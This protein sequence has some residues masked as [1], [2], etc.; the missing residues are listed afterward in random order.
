MRSLLRILSLRYWRRCPARLLLVLLSIA[1]GV[2]AWA[3][4][5]ALNSHLNHSSRVSA[6]PLASCA[7]FLLSN[8]D[9]GVPRALVE[10]LGRIA[11]IHAVRPLIIQRVLLPDLNHQTALLLGAD[12]PEKSSEVVDWDISIRAASSKTYLCALLGGQ[13][14]AL[15]GRELDRL[16]PPDAPSCKVLVGGRTTAVVRTGTIEQARGP[17]AVLAGNVLLMPCAEA[18]T[19]LGRPEL[20]SRIDLRLETGADREAVRQQIEAVVVGAAR[21]SSPEASAQQ[22]EGM[23]APLTLGLAFCGLGALLVGLFLIYNTLAVSVADRRREIA[24]LRALGAT[25]GQVFRLFLGEALCLGIVGTLLGLPLGIGLAKLSLGTMQ[26]VLSEVLLPLSGTAFQTTAG[27]W[28]ES[29]LAGLGTTLLATLVP[30]WHATRAGPIQVLRR[31]PAWPCNMLRWCR[32]GGIPVLTMASVGCV[33]CKNVLPL[34]V[35]T[36]GGLLLIIGV[37]LLAIPSV[38]TGAARLIQGLAR[39]FPS[40]G[41]RIAMDNVVS[42]PGRTGLVVAALAASVALLLMT[43]GLIRSNEAA[44]RSWV[45]ETIGGDLF[46][47]AGGPLSASGQ[48]LPMDETTVRNVQ[49]VLPEALV[50][51]VRFRYLDYRHDGD[52]DRVLLTALDPAT[53]YTAN[54]DRDTPFPGLELYRKLAEEPDGALVSENFA[55]LHRIQ[56]G[57]TITLPGA[58]GTV[59]LRVLGTVMDFSCPRGTVYVDRAR[60]ERPFNADLLDLLG[61]YLPPGADVEACRLRVQQAPWA[62]GQLLCVMT[63]GELRSHVLGMVKRLYGLAYTQEVVVGLVAVLGVVAALLISVL[64]RRRELGLLRAVGATRGQVIG[65]VLAEALLLCTI[66]TALGVIAGLPLEWY[67]LRILLF[68]ETGFRF[69]ILYPWTAF[70]AVSGIALVSAMIAGIGPALHAVRPCIAL[71]LSTEG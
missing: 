43:G 42:A 8:G 65:S 32:F 30:A 57:D 31:L 50:A 10:P 29:L 21:V 53:L 41:A 39:A 47:T 52:A 62:A 67:T 26:R 27:T 45:D 55:A 19:L 68:E 4:T 15:V 44:V 16:L 51:A 70:A 11:G 71:A 66:G 2:A 7:D 14:T 20:V 63:R 24:I 3:A 64:H 9:A 49:Q 18:A 61:V 38:A 37:G 5:R 60:Y 33:A 54:K 36:F 48:T 25:R 56:T 23:L 34:H 12:L 69:P 1:L 17:V 28:F 58:Y 40:I 35:G 13:R 6:S 22:T 46:V 59:R